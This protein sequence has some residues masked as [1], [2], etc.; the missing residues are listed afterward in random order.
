MTEFKVGDK[1]T[2]DPNGS[3]TQKVTKRAV[4]TQEVGT[5]VRVSYP[6]SGF[7]VDFNGE[8]G[9]NISQF[10]IILVTEPTPRD[11]RAE[12]IAYLEGKRDNALALQKKAT[13]EQDAASSRRVALKNQVYEYEQQIALLK[14]GTEKKEW[15]VGAKVKIRPGKSTFSG[16]G[17]IVEVTR[18]GTSVLVRGLITPTDGRKAADLWYGKN[19]LEL[20]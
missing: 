1:V 9:K 14:I 7:D 20:I 18:S 17:R 5:I 15:T 19:E 16:E 11:T 8:V 12:T 3:W 2:L 10:K 4:K 13:E 6:A